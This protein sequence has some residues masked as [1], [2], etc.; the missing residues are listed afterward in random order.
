M[1][2]RRLR[3]AKP[4]DAGVFGGAYRRAA[5][6]WDRPA[7]NTP[8]ATTV[9]EPKVFGLNYLGPD[10]LATAPDTEFFVSGLQASFFLMGCGLVPLRADRNARS[11]ATGYLFPRAAKALMGKFQEA[12]R[13]LLWREQEMMDAENTPSQ[14]QQ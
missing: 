2:K 13:T 14:E 9:E 8:S 1:G 7:S 6:D 10:P 4:Q 5:E 3:E 11:G 12:R